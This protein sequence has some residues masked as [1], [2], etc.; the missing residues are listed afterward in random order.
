MNKMNRIKAQL[1]H[2]VHLVH[3]VSFGSRTASLNRYRDG[4]QHPPEGAARRMDRL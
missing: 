3:P 2:L 4:F 1:H